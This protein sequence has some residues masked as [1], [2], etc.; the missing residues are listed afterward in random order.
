MYPVHTH[1]GATLRAGRGVYDPP[2]EEGML[3]PDDA[4]EALQ[5]RRG[6]VFSL[7]SSIHPPPHSSAASRL[8]LVQFPVSL[9]TNV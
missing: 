6:D 9:T 5:R 2:E 3:L 8:Y 1:G 7:F 4:K